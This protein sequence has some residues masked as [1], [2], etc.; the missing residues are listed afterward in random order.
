MGKTSLEPRIQEEV[1]HYI[2]HYLKPNLGKP[3]NMI[4]NISQAT[5]NII[6]HLLFYKRFDYTDDTFNRTISAVNEKMSL[7]VKIAAVSSLPFGRYILRSTMARETYLT[8]SVLRPTFQSYI[9]SHKG[10]ID[11]DQPRDLIDRYLLHLEGAQG[12]K[13]RSFSGK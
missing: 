6:S 4:H 7:N 13:S 3:F 10:T 9:N 8:Q 12:E 2:N 11:R 1:V 5:C